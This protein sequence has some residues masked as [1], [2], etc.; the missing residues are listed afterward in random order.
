MLWKTEGG[1]GYF[2]HDGPDEIYE[3]TALDIA[4]EYEADGREPKS[5]KAKV[6]LDNG[7]T[8]TIVGRKIAY[9]PLR[10]RRGETT[11]HLGYSMWDYQL[12]GMQEGS[13]IAEHLSQSNT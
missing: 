6:T 8:H 7:T 11:T 2:M 3:V 5:M 10:N 9:I 1:L 12:N 4:T 13:G